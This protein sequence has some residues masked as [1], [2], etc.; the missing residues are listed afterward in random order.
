MRISTEQMHLATQCCWTFLWNLNGQIVPAWQGIVIIWG[1]MIIVGKI[2]TLVVTE[3]SQKYWSFPS[4]V[5]TT[6]HQ[7]IGSGSMKRITCKLEWCATAENILFYI[8][9][10]WL[11]VKIVLSNPILQGYFHY[12]KCNSLRLAKQTLHYLVSLGMI[13]ITKPSR[14]SHLRITNLA[15]NQKVGGVTC[16]KINTLAGT[17]EGSSLYKS[18]GK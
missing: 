16:Q 5:Y 8:N 13:N 15:I 4:Q 12:L 14:V 9:K 11:L 10:L 3:I 18:Q 17:T 7:T 6:C 2:W 1:Q